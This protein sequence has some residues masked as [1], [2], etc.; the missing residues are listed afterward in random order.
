MKEALISLLS[1]LKYP[2]YLQGSLAPNA[3]YPDAF[4]TFWN[5]TTDDHRHYDNDAMSFTWQFDINFYAKDPAL[6]N[7]VL[8]SVRTLLKQNGWIVSGKGYDLGTDEPTTHTG[9]GISVQYL[10]RNIQEQE[11]T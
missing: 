2:V 7:T 10:E 1:T 9:R 11:E 6:V 8:V 5:G 3:P 4:F